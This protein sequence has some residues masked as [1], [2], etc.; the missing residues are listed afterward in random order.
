MITVFVAVVRMR[1]RS[2]A[3]AG[4]PGVRRRQVGTRRVGDE[5]SPQV[6][7]SGALPGLHERGG[8]ARVERGEAVLFTIVGWGR[9]SLAKR[10]REP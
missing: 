9:A 5:R 1:S 2:L 7:V 4:Q 10:T 6:E 8:S 3:G